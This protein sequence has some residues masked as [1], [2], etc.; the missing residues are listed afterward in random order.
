MH[1][2]NLLCTWKIKLNKLTDLKKHVNEFLKS[3][4]ILDEKLLKNSTQIKEAIAFVKLRLS[5]YEIEF[6]IPE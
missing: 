3:S 4:L 5:E 6:M 2:K 1:K